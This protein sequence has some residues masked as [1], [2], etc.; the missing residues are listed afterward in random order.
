[1]KQ[2]DENIPEGYTD[3][4]VLDSIRSV[5]EIDWRAYFDDPLL[6]AL[7]DTAL[8][9]QSGAKYRA[10]GIGGQPE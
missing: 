9:K 2:V 6:I 8:A 3:Q 7:I 10:A 5:V 4:M 1:L